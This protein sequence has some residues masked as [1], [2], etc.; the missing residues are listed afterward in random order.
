MDFERCYMDFHISKKYTK[1]EDYSTSDYI[2][3]KYKIENNPAEK[4]IVSI[5]NLG[6][7]LLSRWEHRHY[8]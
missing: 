7:H 8:R 6:E 5:S 4:K 3:S 1:R 2:L